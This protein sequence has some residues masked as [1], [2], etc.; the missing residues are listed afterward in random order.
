MLSGEGQERTKTLLFLSLLSVTLQFGFEYHGVGKGCRETAG[1]GCTQLGKMM[2]PIFPSRDVPWVG[3]SS[4]DQDTQ[5]RTTSCLC[6]AL[7]PSPEEQQRSLECSRL[8]HGA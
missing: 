6:W 8:F 4:L 7:V 3:L 1:R 5:S 2:F